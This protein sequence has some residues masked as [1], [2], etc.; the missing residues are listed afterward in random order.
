MV[1]QTQREELLKKF[2]AVINEPDLLLKE[3]ER[4]MACS[5]LVPPVVY[6]IYKAERGLELLY[7][8]ELVEELLK[9]DSL[10]T[11]CKVGETLTS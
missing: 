2:R 11:L 10:L 7:I 9:Q 4:L 6:L 8:R 3:R 5:G 1:F